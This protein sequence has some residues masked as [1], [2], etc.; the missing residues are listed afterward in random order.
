MHA[1]E[2]IALLVFLLT[3]GAV[4][5]LEATLLIRFG[6]RPEITVFDI[7]PAKGHTGEN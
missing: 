2:K 6:A 4:Y 3:V 7:G 5:L 1:S